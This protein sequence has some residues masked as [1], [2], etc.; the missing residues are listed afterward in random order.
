MEA[1]L[2]TL[3]TLQNLALNPYRNDNWVLQ[4]PNG[5]TLFN[6]NVPHTQEGATQITDAIK[7]DAERETEAKLL[8]Q[9]QLQATIRQIEALNQAANL[10][11]IQQQAALLQLQQQ[12]QMRNTINAMN[13]NLMMNAF[14]SLNFS[15]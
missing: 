14:S 15:F 7:A 4:S 12:M 13:F 8:E 2:L 5:L 9:A 10:R 1:Q 3:L 6:N 11:Q